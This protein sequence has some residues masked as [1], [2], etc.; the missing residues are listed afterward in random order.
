MVLLSSTEKCVVFQSAEYAVPGAD[1][2]RVNKRCMSLT[3][4]N[5]TSD[6][7]REHIIWVSGKYNYTGLVIG[8]VKINS[9]S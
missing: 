1:L 8:L 5:T 6:K 4:L 9:N 3:A 2:L 7:V